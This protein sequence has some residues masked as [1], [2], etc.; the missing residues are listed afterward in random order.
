MKGNTIVPIEP[1]NA[2]LI[3]ALMDT[4]DE[5]IK[6]WGMMDSFSN[7]FGQGSTMQNDRY[8]DAFFDYD[9]NHRVKRL[10]KDLG[11]SFPWGY[12]TSKILPG[13]DLNTAMIDKIDGIDTVK[14]I[15]VAPNGKTGWQIGLT[16]QSTK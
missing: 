5:S 16:C 9:Q 10:L 7:I 1:T 13:R 11:P 4:S 15:N 3:S 6:G 12:L 8:T 14:I 2:D